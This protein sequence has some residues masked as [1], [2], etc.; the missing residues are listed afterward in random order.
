MVIVSP[1]HRFL[2][3]SPQYGNKVLDIVIRLA[4]LAIDGIL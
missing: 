2:R 3:L 1:R 4:T